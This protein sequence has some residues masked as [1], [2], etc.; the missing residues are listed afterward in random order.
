MPQFDDTLR[1]ALL[2]AWETNIGTGPSLEIR[3]GQPPA[4]CA[5]ADSGT[6]I[7]SLT[8]PSDWMAAASGAAKAMAGTWQAN[9]VAAN[10]ANPLHY[11]IKRSGGSVAVQGSVT[12]T[13]GIAAA[14][15]STTAGSTAVTAPANSV[16]NGAIITGTGIAAGTRLVSGGGTTSWVLSQPATASG[17]VTLTATGEITLQNINL[18]VG[19]QVGF[20][21]FT[22]TDPHA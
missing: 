12:Q 8:L 22:I 14:S 15:C 10:S 19:Q 5:A 9:A 4:N 18:V 20:T 11:R 1:N 2:D 16:P 7:A 21:S 13:G 3:S 6:L 17:T